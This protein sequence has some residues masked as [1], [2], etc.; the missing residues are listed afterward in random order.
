MDFKQL[1]AFITVA[2]TGNVTRAAELLNLVQPAV[3]R[4]LRLLEEDIG[5]ALFERERHG[6]VLTDAG[7]ALLVYA[8]RAML[9]LDRARAEIG[10]AVDGIGGLVT[11]GLL[12]STADI[13][14]SALVSAVAASYP[15]IR[16]RI[17][18][19]YAGTLQQWL[20][21]G[22]I[23]A[24]L[25]YGV[26]RS[27]SILSKPLLEEDLWIVGPAAAKLRR[28]KPVSLASLVGKPLI[29]PSGPHGIR[30]LVDHA[31]A[32]SGVELT[33]M[34][35]TNA[36][37]IQKSLVLGGHGLTV[38]PPIAFADELARGLVSAA[39][40]SGPKITRTIVL[41]LPANRAVGSHVQ[42]TVELLVECARHA[43]VR[44]AWLE[45]RW[46]GD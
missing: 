11:V 44:G 33:V 38:L 5:T 19:G 29:L 6:M 20:E 37:S 24:A 18:M 40:L 7:K 1:R 34:A 26:E 23:D 30:T 15:G 22:E 3:S 14:S 2:D 43:V 36:M 28:Q 8:R 46:L 9:E 27:A 31:C 25:L 13:V 32:V 35:E 4:Q 12:P 10:G 45:A 16:M 42:R 41:A 21:T 17:A 39:P